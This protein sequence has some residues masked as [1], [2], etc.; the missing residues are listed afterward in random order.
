MANIFREGW[1]NGIGFEMG[2]D[3]VFY[4]GSTDQGFEWGSNGRMKAHIYR[5]RRTHRHTY[6]YG[7]GVTTSPALRA[8]SRRHTAIQIHT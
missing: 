7:T 6:R 4:M 2:G 8:T 3:Y 1:A 5:E